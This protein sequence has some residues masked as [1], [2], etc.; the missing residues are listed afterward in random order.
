VAS[1]LEK[2]I[3]PRSRCRINDTPALSAMIKRQHV[4]RS[5]CERYTAHTELVGRPHITSFLPPR[6]L[7]QAPG[8]PRANLQELTVQGLSGSKLK[9]PSKKATEH[10]AHALQPLLRDVWTHSSMRR[11]LSDSARSQGL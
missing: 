5:I 3:F 2:R 4:L 6:I 8:L 9:E 10:C 1:S 11:K 7:D